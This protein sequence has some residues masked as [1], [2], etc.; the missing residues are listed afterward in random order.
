MQARQS[1]QPI[2]RSGQTIIDGA[3]NM[4]MAAKQLA[5]NPKDPPTYQQYS[6]H[7]H[8]VSA[9]IKD[10]L[11]AIRSGVFSCVCGRGMHPLVKII[12]P[13]EKGRNCF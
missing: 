12:S 8:S 3:C 1:Q 2:T 11:S 13:L 10:L 9:G 7:S 5:I 4:V 6:A